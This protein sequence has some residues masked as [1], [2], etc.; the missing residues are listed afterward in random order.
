MSGEK[1]TTIAFIKGVMQHPVPGAWYDAW[2]C[3][4]CS[5]VLTIAEMQRNGP[6]TP[7]PMAPAD[8]HMRFICPRCKADR[9]YGANDRKVLQVPP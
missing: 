8:L 2:T 7:Q 9:L 6:G 5:M 4:E 1:P 3:L